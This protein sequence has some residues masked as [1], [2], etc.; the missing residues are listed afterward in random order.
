MADYIRREVTIRRIEYSL[1]ASTTI[2]EIRKL[3]NGV[4]QE[5]G[6]PA[7]WDDAASVTADDERI[8]FWWEVRD[9]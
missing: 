9:A 3:I 7:G 1:P 5:L 6:D 2:G 4:N 8:T